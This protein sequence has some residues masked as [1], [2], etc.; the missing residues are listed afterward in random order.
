[1]ADSGISR[2]V[3]LITVALAATSCTNDDAPAAAFASSSA[4]IVTTTTAVTTT[5]PPRA[6]L[7]TVIDD[8]AKEQ[9]VRFSVVAVDFTT[10]A[11]A[12]HLADRQVRSASLYKLFVA[13]ELL[14][15]IYAGELRRDAPARDSKGRTVGECLR[16]MIVMSDNDCGV[17][18]LNMVGRGKQDAELVHAGYVSTSLASPQLTSADDIALFFTRVRDGT[19]LGKG[20]E[21]ASAELYQL[22]KEQQVNDRLPA[23]LP[24]STPIAHKTG[25]IRTW[26]HDAGVITTPNGDVLV[27]I[28]SGPWP[29]PCCD[30]DHPGEAERVAFGKIA[31]LGRS[32]YDA[33]A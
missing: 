29:P 25:D 32:I 30:A 33:V 31:E 7:Q 14:R 28:L 26:A 8:F 15:R 4:A 27:A 18:G 19:L 17:A 23:G 11:R 10:G 5:S 22:L 12:R 24:A 13:R 9:S 21:K 20:D 1:V 16:A 2:I 6:D 3:L